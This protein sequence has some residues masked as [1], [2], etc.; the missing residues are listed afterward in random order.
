MRI[1]IELELDDTVL[2]VTHDTRIV[3]SMS[4]D[5]SVLAARLLATAA[6]RL[7]ATIGVGSDVPMSELVA[8]FNETIWRTTRCSP[9]TSDHTCDGVGCC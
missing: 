9:P 1:G 8:G 2:S 7:L 3:Q 4:S 6:G 5:R